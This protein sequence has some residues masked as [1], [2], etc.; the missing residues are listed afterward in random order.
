MVVR[1]RDLFEIGDPLVF[2]LPVFEVLPNATPPTNKL[3][4]KDMVTTKRAFSFHKNICNHCHAIPNLK[5][6]LNMR[7]D[8]KLDVFTMAKRQGT[9]FRWE[10]F[11]IGTKEDPF[12]DERMD[13][14]RHGNKMV[15]VISQPNNPITI[16]KTL[17][18]G[19]SSV[20]VGLRLYGIK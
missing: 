5:Q 11:Y 15:Q 17:I 16:V 7:D 14:E 20:L 6:W 18:L 1:R 8:Q 19:L 10:A 9:L 13:W 12:F 4:L 3:I 2:A